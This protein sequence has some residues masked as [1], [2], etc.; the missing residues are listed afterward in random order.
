MLQVIT[1]A[2][3]LITGLFVPKE[4]VKQTAS[5]KKQ[6]CL[7]TNWEPKKTDFHSKQNIHL[8]QENKKMK[9]ENERETI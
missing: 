8:F 9:N 7:E 4:P 2:I 1:S 6:L 5:V 3:L